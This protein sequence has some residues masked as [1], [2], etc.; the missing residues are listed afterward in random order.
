MMLSFS[1]G[2]GSKIWK[3]DL[4]F[5]AIYGPATPEL[6]FLYK[7]DW[8]LEFF[9]EGYPSIDIDLWLLNICFQLLI[10]GYHSSK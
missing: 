2:H 9:V 5:L 3:K 1:A 8:S 10:L 7:G 6:L 4:A